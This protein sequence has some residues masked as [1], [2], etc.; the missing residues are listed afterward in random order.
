MQYAIKAMTLGEIL[1]ESIKLLRRKWKDFFTIA[2]VLYF[3]LALIQQLLTHYMASDG[4]TDPATAI[5][6]GFG[7]IGFAFL[8]LVLVYPILNAALVTA[9]GEEYIGNPISPKEAIRRAVGVYPAMIVA[10]I[11]VAI[12]VG[13][14]FMLLII[15]GIYLA[16][17]YSVVNQVVVLERKTGMAALRRSSELLKGNMGTA[18]VL[19]FIVFIISFFLGLIAAF[20]PTKIL[21][22][23]AT[24]ALE[25]IAVVFAS[26]TYIVFYFSCRS[27]IEHYDL[28]LLAQGMGEHA[29]M[30][31]SYGVPQQPAY[32]ALSEPAYNPAPP[33]PPPPSL[34]Q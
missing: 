34:P 14:G 25:S 19:G 9:I 17:R 12:F 29:P 7:S 26:A 8:F 32:T 27:K 23:I 24:A 6:A 15:P 4:P 22:A 20:I 30:V 13:L 18:F 21:T 31:E 33:P 1:D 2:A 5:A 3:P 10:A 16:L 28:Q 11:L